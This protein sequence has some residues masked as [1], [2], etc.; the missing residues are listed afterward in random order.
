MKTD[1]KEL[2]KGLQMTADLFIGANTS[3]IRK[4]MT[5]AADRLEELE[6][7][8]AAER[9]IADRL[10]TA[11]QG[12]DLEWVDLDDETDAHDF[13]DLALMTWKEARSDP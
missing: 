4:T 5:L 8:L 13:A 11:L 2:A 10:A 3:E 12:L 9:A 7:E 6:R 1:T